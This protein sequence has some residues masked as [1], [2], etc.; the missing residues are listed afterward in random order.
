MYGPLYSLPV[1]LI[2][3]SHSFDSRSSARTFRLSRRLVFSLVTIREGRTPSMG[4][5]LTCKGHP[6]PTDVNQSADGGDPRKTS[7]M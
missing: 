1:A 2:G 3:L 7:A 6:H 4:L 5:P